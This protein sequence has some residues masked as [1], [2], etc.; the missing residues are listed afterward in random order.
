MSALHAR[1]ELVHR[2]NTLNDEQ[3][4]TLLQF[5]KTIQAEETTEP[6]N[7]ANDPLLTG[8][9]TFKASSDFAEKSEEILRS[10]LGTR[11]KPTGK[12]E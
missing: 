2:L 5:I 4:I 10:E 1:E 11:L 7:Q 3:I 12:N 8:E 6:Y 9:L